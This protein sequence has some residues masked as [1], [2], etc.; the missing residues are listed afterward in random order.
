MKSCLN[1]V[2]FLGVSKCWPFHTPCLYHLRSGLACHQDGSL[3]V[4][5]KLRARTQS[6]PLKDCV[7][8]FI[9]LYFISESFF[10]LRI[11]LTKHHLIKHGGRM[12]GGSLTF[13]CPCK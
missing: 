6:C 13:N 8:T 11:K 12:C 5:F 4:C 2:Y 7:Q 3:F 9:Q 1:L 10:T